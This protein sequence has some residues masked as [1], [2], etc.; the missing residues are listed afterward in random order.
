MYRTELGDLFR[1]QI[2][3]RLCFGFAAAPIW[4][5]S[6]THLH[7]ARESSFFLPTHLRFKI[8]GRAIEQERR[9]AAGPTGRSFGIVVWTN[10][11]F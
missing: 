7:E 5:A 6:P 10:G 1:P 2:Q 3:A 8:L 9:L 4:G 11:W